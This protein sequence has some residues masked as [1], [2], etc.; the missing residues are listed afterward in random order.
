MVIWFY[1]RMDIYFLSDKA[2]TAIDKSCGKRFVESIIDDG[3]NKL[4]SLEEIYTIK[5]LCIATK[6]D[7][8]ELISIEL[9]RNGFYFRL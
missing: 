1:L 3:C 8:L 2:T 7:C 6:R 9:Y 5:N 4:K